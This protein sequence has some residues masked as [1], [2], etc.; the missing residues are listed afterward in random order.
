MLGYFLTSESVTEGHP[1]KLC[2]QISDA[3]LDEYI[4]RDKDSRVAVE[5][6]ACGDVVM[7]AGEVTSGATVDVDAISRQVIKDAGYTDGALGIDFK[8]CLIITN[9]RR[10]SPDIKTGVDKRSG[11]PTGAGDQGIMYGYATKE[12]E[13]FMPLPIDLAHTLA[14]RLAALRKER[15]L[16]WLRPDG[17]TQVTVEYDRNGKPLRVSGVVISTQHDESVDIRNLRAEILSRLIMPEV[18]D[19]W[20]NEETAVYI[21]PTGRFTVGGPAADTGLTGRKIMVDTY[22]GAARHGGGAFSG[23][24]P[25]KVDRSSAYMARYAAKNLVACGLADRCEVSAAYAIGM[26]E[27]VAISVNTFGT[28]KIDD[29]KLSVLTPRLFPFSVD[30]IIEEL[31]LKNVRYRPAATYGHFGREPGDSSFTWEALKDVSACI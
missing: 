9:M 31:D 14:R 23:K 12:T 30:G 20:M 21:N 2:D 5:V 28:G 7:I 4:S 19:R 26:P 6:M 3:L 17:K 11:K 24:D 22:G 16:P 18:G 8:N 13:S 10:Q 1:D 29:G 15:I 25:T 27:P